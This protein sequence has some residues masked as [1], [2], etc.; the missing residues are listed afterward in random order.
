MATTAESYTSVASRSRFPQGNPMMRR[1]IQQR[2]GDNRTLGKTRANVGKTERIVSLA[3]GSILGLLGL[4]RRD[5]L[6]L[7]IGGVG[8][9]L[10]YRGATGHCH[11]YQA[12]GIDTTDGQTREGIH[13]SQSFLIDKSPE[14]LYAYWRN[15]E[16]LPQI[17]THLKSVRVMEDGRSHWVATAPAIVGGKV[18]WDAEITA[19]EPNSRIAWRIAAGI[20]SS[21]IAA[22]CNSRSAPGDRGTAVRVEMEYSPPAGRLG[23]WVA[24]LFGEAPDQQIREDLRNFKR[25]MEVGEVADHRRATARQLRRD[26]DAS[27][28]PKFATGLCLQA[29]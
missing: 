9:G 16:N 26:G 25:V 21:S 24:K 22:P 14:E 19:D 4:R 29:A 11:T 27:T 10:L 1:M 8:G 7:L 5:A 28:A 18:E 23:H 20:R 17:M 2:D 3:A 13:V 6:G 12:L 15:F